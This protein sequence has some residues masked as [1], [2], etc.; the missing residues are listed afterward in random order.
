[1]LLQI[2]S[3]LSHGE[4][5][6]WLNGEIAA[7]R[8]EV[9]ERQAR[10]YMQVASNRTRESNLLEATSIRAALELLSDKERA[11]EQQG[12]LID[13]EAE[14]QLRLAAQEMAEVERQL[15]LAAQE[16]AE[17]ESEARGIFE[18]RA[19]ESQADPPHGVFIQPRNEE[20]QR[21]NRAGLFLAC[22]NATRRHSLYHRI[23][24]H[25]TRV[26]TRNLKPTPAA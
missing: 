23:V 4:W 12:S 5:L 6:P 2:K 7:G 24:N 18:Q 19:R 26:C 9:G 25:S 17:A 21:S 10:R 14:R 22:E 1:M 3:G 16:R 13:V 11:E 15:R 20:A 8:L